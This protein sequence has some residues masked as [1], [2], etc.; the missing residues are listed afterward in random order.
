M[1]HFA[2]H[3]SLCP[4]KHTLHAPQSTMLNWKL[5]ELYCPGCSCQHS[6]CSEWSGKE[7]K[8]F[9]FFTHHTP[10]ERYFVCVKP[11]YLP[12][13][14]LMGAVLNAGRGLWAVYGKLCWS[15]KTR[16]R[17]ARLVD[18]NGR[19]Q[20]M[21]AA[22]RKWECVCEIRN[23]QSCVGKAAGGERAVQQTGSH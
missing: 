21:Q 20:K 13:E 10:S 14:F 3:L 17:A 12:S 2:T 8:S 18:G 19:W 9:T 1:L 7:W 11:L 16:T 5:R 23:L 6:P 22:N 15:R 4:H